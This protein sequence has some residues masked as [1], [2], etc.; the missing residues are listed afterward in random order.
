MLISRK[1]TFW[2][3]FIKIL[4][5]LNCFRKNHLTQDHFTFKAMGRSCFLTSWSYWIK[6]EPPQFF[7][8]YFILWNF[9]KFRLVF[10]QIWQTM[11]NSRVVKLSVNKKVRPLEVVLGI[12]ML[13]IRIKETIYRYILEMT[14]LF[15]IVYNFRKCRWFR[16]SHFRCSCF[17][18][19]MG[20]CVV[21]LLMALYLQSFFRIGK[22]VII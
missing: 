10:Y 4:I 20:S 17:F 7:Q 8:I 19:V 12:C 22:V 6:E 1:I 14:W 11:K 2:E 5:K 21:Q 16:Y 18:V 9:Y 15:N 3:I 13:P